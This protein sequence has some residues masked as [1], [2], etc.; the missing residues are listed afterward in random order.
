MMSISLEVGMTTL[1]SWRHYR[2]GCF[3]FVRFPGSAASASAS[4]AAAASAPDEVPADPSGAYDPEYPRPPLDRGDLV[5]A[6]HYDDGHRYEYCPYR[7]WISHPSRSSPAGKRPI[8]SI[9]SASGRLGR[10]RSGRNGSPA[11]M[12]VPARAARAAGRHCP[13]HRRG[14]NPYRYPFP[15]HYQRSF[16]GED[17]ARSV[18]GLLVCCPGDLGRR[19]GAVPQSPAE[20]PN[21]SALRRERFCPR[22]RRRCYCCCCCRYSH[23]FALRVFCL[24]SSLTKN[25]FDQEQPGQNR[26][27]CLL[28]R[29]VLLVAFIKIQFFSDRTINCNYLSRNPAAH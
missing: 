9:L 23:R 24:N 4:A 8:G 6:Q 25:P 13:C 21:C 7:D 5:V 3:C 19:R 28:T 29:Y 15:P 27:E 12:A 1:I 17:F 16:L 10:N 22:D 20:G 14:H 11:A 18:V 2:F 26:I